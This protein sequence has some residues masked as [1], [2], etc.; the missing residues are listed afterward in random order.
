MRLFLRL[1]F[2][3]ALDSSASASTPIAAVA[4]GTIKAK[5]TAA[6]NQACRRETRVSLPRGIEDGPQPSLH[7]RRAADGQRQSG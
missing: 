2:C 5:A 3:S 1:C 7:P 6:A 4:N